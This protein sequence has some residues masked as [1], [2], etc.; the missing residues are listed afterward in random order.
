MNNP[1]AAPSFASISATGTY[2]TGPFFDDLAVG[3]YSVQMGSITLNGVT[4]TSFTGTS[5]F[6]L[7]VV[8]PCLSSTLTWGLP[9]LISMTFSVSQLDGSGFNLYASQ[10]APSVLDLVSQIYNLPSFCGAITFS[11]S[12]TPTGGAAALTGTELIVNS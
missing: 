6:D 10:T 7:T 8:D 11:I 12:S 9:A 1:T 5:S 2:T 3:V 4:V